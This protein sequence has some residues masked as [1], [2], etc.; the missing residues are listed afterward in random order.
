MFVE[1]ESYT[2]IQKFVSAYLLSGTERYSRF[3]RLS[4][5]L[6]KRYGHFHN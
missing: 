4:L 2:I 3:F 6:P 5:A 1:D